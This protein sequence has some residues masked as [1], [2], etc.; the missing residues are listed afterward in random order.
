M[1]RV[2]SSDWMKE[3]FTD[4]AR[5]V[6]SEN[7]L[8]VG[9][10]SVCLSVCFPNVNAVARVIRRI[11]KVSCPTAAAVSVLRCDPKD[12]HQ[13]WL[14]LSRWIAPGDPFPAVSSLRRSELVLNFSFKTPFEPAVCYFCMHINHNF[15]RSIRFNHISLQ[16]KFKLN[17]NSPTVSE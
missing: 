3:Q 2:D 6:Y 14:A 4:V 8:C 16:Q 15:I 10:M 1:S 13:H 17:K 12:E 9:R 5:H 7:S 11:L